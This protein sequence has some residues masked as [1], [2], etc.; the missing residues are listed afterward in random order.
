MYTVT[1]LKLYA[2]TRSVNKDEYKTLFF[3]PK[4]IMTFL[5]CTYHKKEFKVIRE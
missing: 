4:E 2:E 1:T 3:G 5:V